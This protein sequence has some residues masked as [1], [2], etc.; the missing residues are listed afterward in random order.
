MRL[1]PK[2]LRNIE[3][4][5]REKKRLLKESKRMEEEGFLSLGSIVNNKA[6]KDGSDSGLLDLLPISNPLV[7]VLIKLVKQRFFNK[8]NNSKTG[9]TVPGAEEKR[10]KNPLKSIAVEFIGGYLKWKAIEL[11]YEGMRLLIKRRKEKR[12]ADQ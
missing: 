5:E 7:T 10:R 8:D 1:Y 9:N 11:S 12:A 4:L 2:R 6:D 3:D